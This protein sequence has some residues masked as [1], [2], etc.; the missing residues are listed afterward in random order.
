MYQPHRYVKAIL[1]FLQKILLNRAI[2]NSCFANLSPIFTIFVILVNDDTV[3]RSYDYGS[4]GNY[5]GEKIC[6]TIVTKMGILLHWLAQA[7]YRVYNTVWYII[8]KPIHSSVQ[9]CLRNCDIVYVKIRVG[10]LT[11]IFQIITVE[12]PIIIVI[13]IIS[14]CLQ[15]PLACWMD[16]LFND[17]S[18]S[19]AHPVFSLHQSI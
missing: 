1:P 10:N 4:H 14:K 12:L 19:V 3:D 7:E 8:G 13:N 15:T 16:Q 11:D 9:W 17:V 6:V 5:F 18:H 2:Y